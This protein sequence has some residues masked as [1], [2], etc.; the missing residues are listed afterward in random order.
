M[1]VGFDSGSTK[2]QSHFLNAKRCQLAQS[3]S[4]CEADVAIVGCWIAGM[5]SAYFLR[6]AEPDLDIVP[7]KQR[8]LGSG[9]SGATSVMCPTSCARQCLY[10]SM[11]SVKRGRVSFRRDV[12]RFIDQPR[13]RRFG[14]KAN[15]L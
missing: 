4:T 3:G 5:S 2:L 12:M 13:L 7:V 9:S 15:H 1:V 8:F 11:L 6:C 10:S 14:E